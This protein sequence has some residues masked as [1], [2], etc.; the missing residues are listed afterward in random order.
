[1]SGAHA[2]TYYAG[3]G[4]ALT[5]E[6]NGGFPFVHVQSGMIKDR[7]EFRGVFLSN[8]G[9]DG[10]FKTF[11]SADLLGTFPIL[12]DAAR[13]Y[14]GLGLGLFPGYAAGLDFVLGSEYRT[15]SVGIFAE[16]N[17]L[18]SFGL[19]PQARAGLNVYF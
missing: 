3:G 11:I 2:Q 5:T 14:L 12:D 18:V 6:T 17:A 4:V 7:L 16:A 15:G 10:T 8:L 1:M 9:L 13:V 19:L